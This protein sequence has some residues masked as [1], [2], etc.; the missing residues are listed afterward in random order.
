M[1]LSPI[2]M[3][4]QQRPYRNRCSGHQIRLLTEPNLCEVGSCSAILAFDYQPEPLW[5]LCTTGAIAAMIAQTCWGCYPA[6]TRKLQTD[7]GLT[8]FVMVS[9]TSALSCLA[10][11]TQHGLRCG[12]MHLQV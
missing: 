7:G 9:A 11:G 3:P 4:D 12:V 6:I 2:Q 1:N 8:P 5:C 10:M